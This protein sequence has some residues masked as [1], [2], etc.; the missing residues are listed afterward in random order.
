MRKGFLTVL[1]LVIFPPVVLEA[2]FNWGQR[3][4][5]TYKQLEQQFAEPDMIYAPFTFWFWDEPIQPDK[6]QTMAET[7]TRQRLN[8]GY[9]HGRM[10]M[11]G[12][13]DL[14]RV[15]WLG[16]VWMEAFDKALSKAEAADCYFGYVDEYW[17]PSGR[18]A[19]RTLREN[20]DLWAISLRWETIDLTGPASLR[21][22]ECSFAIAAQLTKPLK[23]QQPIRGGRIGPDGKPEPHKPATILSKSIRL[24]SGE[25]KDV[26][27]PEG[28]WRIYAFIQY[29][30]PG[31]DGGRLNYLDD[32][33]APAFLK[34]A[35][36][37]YADRFG[38]RMGT[39]IPGV[40]VDNEG[41]YGYKLA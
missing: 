23:T 4:F 29:Y 15:Q 3:K 24:I 40:F 10:C 33:V 20:P 11:V 8:P 17:W 36:Q 35:H 13:P 5:I 2:E 30:H 22:P 39:S 26:F 28:S 32:R 41:D 1:F 9:A 6:M 37:P 21:L 12:L 34:L 25:T 7:M 31:A 19:D 16:P 18:A 14:P 38:R 27:L